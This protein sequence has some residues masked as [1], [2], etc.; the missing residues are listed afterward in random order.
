MS[1]SPT[2][3][4]PGDR[5][6]RA[7]RH[8]LGRLLLCVGSSAALAAPVP[9]GTWEHALSAYQPP[10]Y[11]KDFHHFEYVNP[12][13]PKG[14]LLRLGNPDRRT[15]IDKLN[16][17]TIKGV[18]PAALD[19]F[20]FES[21]CSFSMDEPQAMYG[22]LAEAMLVAPDLS[23][24]SFRLN[25]LA[26]FNNGDQVTPEDVADSF[27]R[28]KGKLVSPTYSTPLAGVERAVVVDANTVRFDLKDR[29]VDSLFALGYMRVFSR[30]WGGGKPLSK[31]DPIVKTI[32]QSI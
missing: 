15:S 1:I 16:P 31:V 27:K 25:P 30:K 9:T 26:R 6:V 18:A 28:L 12:D 4:L 8:W 17:F 10:K 22:L 21:L 19:M 32:F 29:T 5:T 24:I 14:G 11:A 13:A 7:F 20:M 23:S 3:S 2:F